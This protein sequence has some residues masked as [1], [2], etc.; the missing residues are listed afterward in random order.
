MSRLLTRRGLLERCAVFGALSFAIPTTIS[1][2]AE[3]WESAE[4]KKL[5]PT[6]RC[7]LGPFYRRGAPNTAHMR[8]E[9]DTGMPLLLSGT[10]FSESGEALS[11]GKVEVWQTD[12]YGHYDIEGYRFRASLIADQKGTYLVNSVMPGHYPDR[13]C[14]H[15][16]YLVTAP[17]HKPLVTQLYFGTDP[18]FDGDPGKNFHRDPLITSMELVRPVVIK[19]DP[20]AMIAAVNFDV[21]LEKR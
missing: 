9:Q 7:E 2:L 14:Q 19:G 8:T 11:N 20:K 6:P 3:A 13:V 4:M 1:Q 21:V 16:H 18:V 10:V 17:G 15:I 12:H 5:S